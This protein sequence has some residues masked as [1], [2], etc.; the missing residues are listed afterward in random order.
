MRITERK[1]RY[2]VRKI[3]LEQDD[4]LPDDEDLYVP[5]KKA[6]TAEDYRSLL[7]KAILKEKQDLA[8]KSQLSNKLID[9]VLKVLG[10]IA[11]GIDN[12]D[13]NS[14]AYIRHIGFNSDGSVFR[15]SLKN[16]K[17]SSEVKNA[18]NNAPQMNPIVVIVPSVFDKLADQEKANTLEH[19]V[20]HIRNNFL[21]MKTGLSLNVEEVRSVLRKD[22][23]GKKTEEVIKILTSEGRFE[24]AKDSIEA[25]S[26]KRLIEKMQEYYEGVFVDPADELAVD[27]F[28]VR[29]GKLQDYPGA[30]SNN[31]GK[32]FNNLEKEYSADA[33][34]AI[35]Y[36]DKNTAIKDV[37]RVVKNLA[38]EADSIKA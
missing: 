31:K 21:K 33:A 29:I 14:K 32:T 27:E 8:G 5:R 37:N 30:V 9:D 23:K 26:T 18:Y 28:A 35:I 7:N 16:V 24:K 20:N 2:I 11:L 19:E 6:K 15:E 13:P 3:L 10:N 17:V 36:L 34:Q 12:M 25:A 22:L 1:I 4:W 38:K